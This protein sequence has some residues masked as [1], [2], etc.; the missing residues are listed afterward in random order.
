MAL[1]GISDENAASFE[2]E[3]IFFKIAKMF[4]V[5]DT[6]NNIARSWNL[7]DSRA[8]NDALPHCTASSSYRLLTILPL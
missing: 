1:E 4:R 7:L 6:V 2:A 5:T 3:V 8:H